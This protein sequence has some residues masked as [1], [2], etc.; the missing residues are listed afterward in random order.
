MYQRYFAANMLAFSSD[1][2]QLI[3]PIKTDMFR[4]LFASGEIRDVVEVQ[5]AAENAL[6]LPPLRGLARSVAARRAAGYGY[7]RKL[8][9]PGEAPACLTQFERPGLG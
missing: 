1:Y 5:T 4:Q 2:D 9:I 3:G 6:P 7:R 8:R